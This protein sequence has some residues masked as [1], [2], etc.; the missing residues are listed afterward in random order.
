MKIL[1]VSTVLWLLPTLH[2]A[3]Q[4]ADGAG[5]VREVLDKYCVTCHN[6]RLKTASLTLD[7]ADLSHVPARPELWE[8]VLRKLT[9]R[10]HAAC[11][12]P[13]ARASYLQ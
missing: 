1:R 9:L 12:H 4:P 10:H 13:T 3:P 8:K 5:T 6:Q 2:A 7:D 11:R